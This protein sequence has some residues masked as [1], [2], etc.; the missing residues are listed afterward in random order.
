M[1]LFMRVSI[2]TAFGLWGLALVLFI[3]SYFMLR[4]NKAL[5]FS[6]LLLYLFLNRLHVIFYKEPTS[7][8]EVRTNIGYM[9]MI[10]FEAILIFLFVLVFWIIQ[11]RRKRKQDENN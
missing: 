11:R 10:N 9:L 1:L 2:Y 3:L 7:G 6:L 4:K 5:F 8:N